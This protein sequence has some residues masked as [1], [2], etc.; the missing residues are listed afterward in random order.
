MGSEVAMKEAPIFQAR[1]VGSFAQKPG[2]PDA[3]ADA[4]GPE[5]LERICMGECY[6]PSD[7]RRLITRVE[8]VKI[9]PQ[10]SA[11]EEI[12]GLVHD[13]WRRFDCEPDPSG[14]I[15]TFSDPDYATEGREALY[16]VRA[17]EAET[18]GVN[19]GNLRCERDQAGNCTDVEIC[20][21]P[22]GGRDDCLSPH[23]PRAWSSPIWLDYAG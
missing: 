12:A 17:F 13:P 14:C 5:D 16:Y 10:M 1:A 3:S 20:P 2:C 23:E 9:T 15:V 7:E 4:L 11:G 18:L 22:G 21:N 6:N 19:A 8:I